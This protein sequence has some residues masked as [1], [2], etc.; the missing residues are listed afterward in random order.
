MQNVHSFVY[1]HAD[2]ERQECQQRCLR[3]PTA[4][5]NCT[6][7][8]SCKA[9]CAKVC[10]HAYPLSLRREF[11]DSISSVHHGATTFFSNLVGNIQTLPKDAFNALNGVTGGWFSRIALCVVFAFVL[12]AIYQLRS[13]V[14]LFM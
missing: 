14:S 1:P 10:E 13:V 12:W 8:R 5:K 7:K 4:R 6:D 9:T 2:R 3:T 11:R